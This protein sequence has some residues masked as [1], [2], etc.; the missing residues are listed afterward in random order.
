MTGEPFFAVHEPAGAVRGIALVLHGGRANSGG[1]VRAHQVAVVR[2]MPFIT[3][4]S[5][6]GHAR[7]LA[8]AR[9]RYLVRGW[10]GSKRAPVPDVLWVL[11]RIAE[12]YPGTPVTLVGH[13]MGGRAAVYAAGHPAVSGVVGLAPW[14]EPGDPYEPV[15]GRD[16]LVLHGDRDRITSAAAAAEWTDQARDVARSAAFVSVHGDGHAMLRRAGLWHA[17][18]TGFV[19]AT[20]CGAAPEETVHGVSTNVV[21][22]VLAGQASFVV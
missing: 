2:M 18:T 20:M 3:S 10:N 15:S 8:V 5:R 13:S 9:M 17:V 7:G 16:V 14:I 6:A 22:K 12:R 1:P 4:L 19:L 11:D 21:A